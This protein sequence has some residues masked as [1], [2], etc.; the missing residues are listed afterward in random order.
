M[1]EWTKKQLH[2][3]NYRVPEPYRDQVYNVTNI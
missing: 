3:H 1:H 2:A